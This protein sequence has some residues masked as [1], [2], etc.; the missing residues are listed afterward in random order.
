L[1]DSPFGGCV[2]DCS[3]ASLQ[4]TVHE[5][6]TLSPLRSGRRSQMSKKIV[7]T[8]ALVVMVVP[9]VAGVAFATDQI[10]QCRHT[11]CYGS[12]ND[13]LVYERVGNSK[14]DRIILKGGRD[15]VLANAYTNDAD[16]IRGGSG[17]DRINV[18][19]GD[20]RDSAGGGDGGRDYCIVDVRIEAGPGCERVTVQ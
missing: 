18:A 8:V 9:L 11:P 13:D 3:V 2:I 6:G 14:N 1:K 10:I 19:D 20:R 7:M 16:V 15:R 12:G 5:E 17:F 4:Q